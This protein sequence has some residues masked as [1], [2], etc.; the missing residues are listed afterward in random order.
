MKVEEQLLPSPELKPLYERI[1]WLYVYRDFS[2]SES[3]RAA[4]RIEL[5]FGVT[6][7][8]QMMLV[9]P[10]NWEVLGHTG[11]TVDSFERAV[12]RASVGPPSAQ[13]IPRYRQAERLAVALERD[14]SRAEQS[15]THQDPVVR[16][17]AL[18]ALAGKNPRAIVERAEKLLAIPHDPFRFE[19]L[20]VLEKHGDGL[21]AR[22]LEKLLAHPE[23]SLNPNAL[24][25]QTARALG[26]CGDARSVEA[27]A[28]Y[29]RGSPQ[30]TLTSTSVEALAAIAER[31][32]ATV[33]AVTRILAEAY[34]AP[35]N[36]DLARRVHQALET[37]TG[38][39]VP[40]P[41]PYDEAARQRLMR[42]W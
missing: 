32:P 37:V 6:S 2:G 10:S 42:S 33:R 40:F 15:L 41:E 39:T 18:Q 23:P 8:P 4:E 9:D 21:Q 29:T 3:D 25:I 26:R 24:R 36:R 12:A 38:R 14:P 19:V 11:R 5:R 34:P 20:R 1:T 28:G 30:N 27:L 17:R 22:A 7:Y 31:H 35:G 13:A 16:M